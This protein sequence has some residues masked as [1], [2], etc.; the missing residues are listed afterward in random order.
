[1]LFTLMYSLNKI[2]LLQLQQLISCDIFIIFVKTFNTTH[3]MHTAYKRRANN[4]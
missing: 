3:R 2:N 1:M 4:T